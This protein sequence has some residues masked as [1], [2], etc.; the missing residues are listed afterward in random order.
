M[1]QGLVKKVVGS[2]V[3]THAQVLG[4]SICI[5]ERPLLGSNS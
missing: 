3:W 5:L 4:V 2:F 1:R